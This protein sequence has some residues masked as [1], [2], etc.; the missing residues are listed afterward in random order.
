[1]EEHRLRETHTQLIFD[2]WESQDDTSWLM[3]LNYTMFM[4][5]FLKL[6]RKWNILSSS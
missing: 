6:R 2:Y 1:M 3:V 4:R 5:I